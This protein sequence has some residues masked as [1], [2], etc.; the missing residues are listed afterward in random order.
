M[1]KNNILHNQSS[2]LENNSKDLL[3]EFDSVTTRYS[4]NGENVTENLSL[5]I[6]T[7]KYQ[8]RFIVFVG[9]SGC[10]KSTLLKTL[11]GLMLPITGYVKV[12]G[13][14]VKAPSGKRSLVFQDYACFDWLTAL[15]NVSFPLTLKGVKK[16]DARH[17]AIK[18]LEMVGLKE[19]AKKYPKELSGGMR[20][21]VAIAR[22]LINKPDL[23]LM[24]EP[25]GPLDAFTREEMQRQL[26]GLW[27]GS[28]NNIIFVTHDIGE[29]LFL[30]EEVYV[31]SARP[32]QVYAKHEINI[33]FEERTRDLKYTEEFANMSKDIEDEI[34]SAS[35]LR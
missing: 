4:T 1:S 24:D 23:L 3:F 20:Q 19:I 16:T 12:L 9:P 2:E 28:N 32:M 25:F 15:D 29:A 26:L 7:G 6:E 30:G 11:A 5:H 8:G 13:E 34:R 35:S 17:E 27:Y 18:Y 10:G 31:M 33:P 14:L 22:T 21:R